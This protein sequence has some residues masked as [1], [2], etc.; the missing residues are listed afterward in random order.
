VRLAEQDLIFA[1]ELSKE[2]VRF[3]PQFMEGVIKGRVVDN[4]CAPRPSKLSALSRTEARQVLLYSKYHCEPWSHRWAEALRPC[5]R[6]RFVPDWCEE[7][8]EELAAAHL[9]VDPYFETLT[10]GLRTSESEL[11][12][13]NMMAIVIDRLE[14][15]D[16]RDHLLRDKQ[17]WA[18]VAATTFLERASPDEA[19]RI[20]WSLFLT[21]LSE[22]PAMAEVFGKYATRVPEATEE[23]ERMLH[24]IAQGLPGRSMPM[25]VRELLR[26]RF[27]P[28][29]PAPPSA[30][31]PD[32]MNP[33]DI[34]L[35]AERVEAY[36]RLLRD[37]KFNESWQMLEAN[38]TDGADPG[39]YVRTQ[40]YLRS[41]ED[42]V[43]WQVLR[44]QVKEDIAQVFL[45]ARYQQKSGL[46]RR[47]EESVREF[48]TY[49]VFENDSWYLMLPGPPFFD[50]SHPIEV[51]IPSRP[52]QNEL[53]ESN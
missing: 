34:A 44:I 40:R 45:K 18:T 20:G 9:A 46:S 17:A 3:G 36:H 49:W 37:E 8:N 32:R 6:D 21:P 2:G 39:G 47:K 24:L 4:G 38:R 52:P 14:G 41:L 7:G 1:R 23:Q 35:L 5:D 48:A 50:K 53:N 51:P 43:D 25:D 29:L 27:G 28:S 12:R 13:T 33:E 16:L 26:G 31:A 19:I 30:P 11:E 42:L 15:E 22:T 10:V